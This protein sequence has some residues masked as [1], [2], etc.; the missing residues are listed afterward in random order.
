MLGDEAFFLPTAAAG[1]HEG[2]SS[3]KA[4]RALLSSIRTHCMSFQSIIGCGVD[5]RKDFYANAALSSGTTLFAG[6][7][8]Q[9]TKRLAVLAPMS[10]KNQVVALPVSKY[11]V[12]IGG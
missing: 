3:C 5:V 11:S 10:T 12:W 1:H 8:G 7:C 4:S 6:I 9:V 2:S